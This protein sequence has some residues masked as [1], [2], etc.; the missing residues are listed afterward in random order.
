MGNE[1]NANSGLALAAEAI[2]VI[3]GQRTSV[4]MDLATSPGADPTRSA[5]TVVNS[6][7]SVAAG[8]LGTALL[9]DTREQTVRVSTGTPGKGATIIAT[10][11]KSPVGTATP[12]P[13]IFVYDKGAQMVT[14]N[15][16]A[17]RVHFFIYAAEDFPNLNR[18]GWDLYDAAIDW[19]MG[20]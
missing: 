11:W 15:A 19:A 12:N 3:S 9:S 20:L 17:R 1:A 6:A 2:P 13:T 7:H 4:S 8:F 18:D 10:G 14:K 16:P 5:I